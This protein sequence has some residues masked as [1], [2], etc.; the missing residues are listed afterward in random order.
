MFL[1]VNAS[2]AT[3]LRRELLPIVESAARP[4]V[5]ELTEHEHVD[6]YGQ[7]DRARRELRDLGVRIA[8]D[9]TGTG[10]ASLE[11]ILRL[12][13][14]IIKLDRFFVSGVD[15]DPVRRGLATA[16]VQFSADIGATLVAEG[17][18][19]EGELRV[20]R[21]LGIDHGQGY[22]IAR[23]GPLPLDVLHLASAA[24]PTAG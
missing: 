17:I 7:L 21:D 18:E 23:P 19:T 10:Y 16:L 9:D 24:D 15:E 2:P 20:L 4:I 8:V 22:F 11:H 1:S 12:H 6:D 3:V 14:E 5:I 13:P